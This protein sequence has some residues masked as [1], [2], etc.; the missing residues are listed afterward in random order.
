M[1]PR[2]FS[3]VILLGIIAVMILAGTGGFLVGKKKQMPSPEKTVPQGVSSQKVEGEIQLTEMH[4]IEG[5][6]KPILSP[7]QSIQPSK[8]ATR[9]E[10]KP[11]SAPPLSLFPL[12]L[13]NICSG[14][15]ECTSYCHNHRGRCEAY[16]KENNKNELCR[17]LFPLEG[18]SS[19]GN[20][21]ELFTTSPVSFGD[22]EVVVPLG[23]LNPPGHI[24]PTDHIYMHVRSSNGVSNIL[25]KFNVVSPGEVSITRISSSEHPSAHPPF[26]DYDLEFYPCKEIYAKFGHVTFLSQKL[27]SHFDQA[28]GECI[29]NRDGGNYCNKN[30]N[31][32]LAAGEEIG[33]TV[34][35][36]GA[37]TGIDVWLADYRTEKISYA[38]PSR[39]SGVSFHIVCPVD[40]FIEDIRSK[41]YTLF[42]RDGIPR[43]I[44]PICG[45][46]EQDALGTAQGVWFVKEINQRSS[47]DPHLALVH[48]NFNPLKGVFSVGTSMIANG[49][50]VGTYYFDPK[51]SGFVNRD[52]K[53]VMSDGN[54]YCYDSLTKKFDN[55]A[56]PMIIILQL[57]SGTTL[58]IEKQNISECGGGPWNF[59]TFAEFER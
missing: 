5:V 34:G 35:I 55:Q 27:Q 21:K 6:I 48:D 57:T 22:L 46:V 56:S 49:L 15:D 18:I 7:A 58:K 51:S 17:T 33:K 54:V 42:K 13:G 16:C 52:F 26:T 28:S 45:T 9:P 10:L 38:N 40:Y 8:S 19:C 39:W 14:Q 50:N 1:N 47:E 3:Q 32:K 59:D 25:E 30:V 53:D 36:K 29:Y 23:N 31:F 11:K 4:T 20:K 2:G 24:F 44:E 43:T 41:M 37:A 12:A